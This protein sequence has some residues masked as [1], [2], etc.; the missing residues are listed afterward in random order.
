MFLIKY[1]KDWIAIFDG[2]EPQHCNHI[3]GI[4]AS[5]IGSKS[6][7]TFEKQALGT[8][9]PRLSGPRLSELFDYPDFFNGP[10]FFSWIL[11]SFDLKSFQR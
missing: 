3:K 4:V 10:V 5:E 11:I 6:F 8:V 9:E 7:R 2:L 1:N